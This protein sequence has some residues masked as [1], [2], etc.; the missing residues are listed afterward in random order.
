M[1]HFHLLSI[2]H[3]FMQNTPL[4]R[5][6]K[7]RKTERK[8]YQ[9]TPVLIFR[10]RV[11]INSGLSYGRIFSKLTLLQEG[12]MSVWKTIR[13]GHSFIMHSFSSFTSLTTLAPTEGEKTFGMFSLDIYPQSWRVYIWILWPF[14]PFSCKTHEKCEKTWENLIHLISMLISMKRKLTMLR[15]KIWMNFLWEKME[16]SWGRLKNFPT[17]RS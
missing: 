3:N 7:Q 11:H 10:L 14:P 16:K 8:P 15:D 4:A 17:I 2:L 12:E 1:A 9:T 13:K 5:S 6:K